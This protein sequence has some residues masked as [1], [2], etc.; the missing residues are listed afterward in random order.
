MIKPEMNDH[1]L[2]RPTTIRWIWRVSIAVLA[3]TVLWQL[4]FPVKGYFAV[5]G[6]LGFG[7]VYGF[8]ACVVMVIVAKGLGLFLK[9]DQHYYDERQSDD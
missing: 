5:D 9:R 3:F 1:W 4:V 6:W 7:A 2:V 8:F